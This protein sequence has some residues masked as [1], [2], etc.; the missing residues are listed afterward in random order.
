MVIVEP[1]SAAIWELIK[2]G[3]RS[4]KSETVTQAE[5][6]DRRLVIWRGDRRRVSLQKYYK[7]NLLILWIIYRVKSNISS[8]GCASP[9]CSFHEFG[10]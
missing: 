3:G 8:S 9:D 6:T 10:V 5:S 2:M 1:V 7:H 4:N